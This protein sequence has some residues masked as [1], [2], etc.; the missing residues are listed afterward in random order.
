MIEVFGHD[1][2]DGTPVLDI[3]PYLPYADSFPEAIQGWLGELTDDP[4]QIEFTE[5]AARQ[6]D[7]LETHGL[8]TLRGFLIQQLAVEPTNGK[9]KRVTP[10]TGNEWEIAY[11][12]WRVQYETHSDDHK[13]KIMRIYSG[14]TKEDLGS[15]TDQYHDKKIHR[16]FNEFY[17]H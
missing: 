10:L 4:W 15:D 13:L 2:L 6:L 14:Y 5:D 7:W 8:D 1:I 3:K 12:T 17:H 11:R 16:D 9:K